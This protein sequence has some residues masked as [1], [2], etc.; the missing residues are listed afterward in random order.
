MA[1]KLKPQKVDSVSAGQAQVDVYLDR[2][3]LDFFAKLGLEEVRAPSAEE[4][5]LLARDLAQ[6]WRPEEWEPFILVER[7][8]KDDAMYH[9]A[10]GVSE[11]FGVT[12]VYRRLE[13]ARRLDG[14]V[15]ERTHE[16]D[17][18]EKLAGMGNERDRKF[19]REQREKLRDCRQSYGRNNEVALPYSDE[20]W[21]ALGRIG[22]SIE[23]AARQLGEMLAAPDADK[24]LQSVGSGRLLTE[25]E[26]RDEE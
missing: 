13:R 24:R 10:L 6:R 20:T 26:R 15:L 21:A 14:V 22:D 23:H 16:L 11:S 25:P 5:R 9:M 18:Q 4:C 12:L 3:K 2:N 7:R 19:M 17:Y 8:V 1:R